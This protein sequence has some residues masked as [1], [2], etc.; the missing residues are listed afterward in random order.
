MFDMGTLKP[1][2]ADRKQEREDRRVRARLQAELLLREAL[3]SHAP[4]GVSLAAVP[5]LVAKRLNV[6]RCD[7]LQ[8]AV[9]P[10]GVC[11]GVLYRV[12]HTR[13]A[14]NAAVRIETVQI[15]TNGSP[16]DVLRAE[17]AVDRLHVLIR[18]IDRGDSLGILSVQN[19]ATRRLSAEERAFL[20]AVGDLVALAIDRHVVISG[21][22]LRAT[23]AKSD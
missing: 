21:E 15:S 1:R 6:E 13:T 23:D 9:P 5:E 4:G 2:V 7:L 10:V 3:A 18:S 17:G 11:T 22:E 8:L 12:R 20:E 14:G 19:P 16:F